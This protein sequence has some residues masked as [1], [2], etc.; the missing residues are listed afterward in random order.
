MN[1]FFP[2]ENT[3]HKPFLFFLLAFSY[4]QVQGQIFPV[5]KYPKGYFIYPVEAKVGLAAN[6]GELRPNHYH[7]GLDCRTDQ[8]INKTVRAAADGYVAH[9][10]VE[11]FGFGQAIYINHPNGL[12]TLYGALKFFLSCP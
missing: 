4:F 5:K 9:V 10:K 1:I 2:K 6:F 11:P 3:L 8:V 7:M 12:T